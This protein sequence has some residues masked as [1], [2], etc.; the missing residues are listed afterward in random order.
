MI[1]VASTSSPLDARAAVAA[2]RHFKLD[3]RGYG[4]NEDPDENCLPQIEAAFYPLL[5]D[6]DSNVD[7][8]EFHRDAS[9]IVIN[10]KH[11]GSSVYAARR[12]GANCT[13]P[14]PRMV[15]RVILDGEVFRQLAR[16]ITW[17][18]N[19]QPPAGP[20]SLVKVHERTA[21]EFEDEQTARSDG[22]T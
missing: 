19:D 10:T 7:S 16:K 21:S 15:I 9:R 22:E 17:R 18:R 1:A 2:A 12:F 5:V 4:E 8:V 11:G 20:V 3:G 6:P 14:S 13:T